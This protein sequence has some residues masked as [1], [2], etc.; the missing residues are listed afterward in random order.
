MFNENRKKAE[1]IIEKTNFIREKSMKKTVL[2]FLTLFA[3]SLFADRPVY[4][5]AILLPLTGDQQSASESINEGIEAYLNYIKQNKGFDSF[6]LKAVLFNTESKKEN[7]EK[8]IQYLAKKSDEFILYSGGLSDAEVDALIKAAEE[9]KTPYIFPI[10]SAFKEKHFQYY[11]PVL[12]SLS[13]GFKFAA[14]FFKE[15]NMDYKIIYDDS[16]R[17]NA[18]LLDESEKL[19][20][21]NSPDF[22]KQLAKAAILFVSDENVEKALKKIGDRGVKFLN[23]HQ[24]NLVHRMTDA[25][26][27]E[28]VLIL[29]W[30]KGE[31]FESVVDFKKNFMEKKKKEPDNFHM[32]GWMLAD[33]TYQGI[34]NASAKKNEKITKEDL[35]AEL[36]KM[37]ENGGYNGGC[38]YKIYYEP[39]LLSNEKSRLG[40]S[41]VYFL[42]YEK[43][44]LKI[45]SE[46][47]P[48]LN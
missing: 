22:E 48:I 1:S 18:F 41:G 32:L 3:G 47:Y 9:K 42:Q 34:V 7:S 16:T 23:Y 24:L 27:W 39:F 44:E 40:I 43:G 14:R 10:R 5:M 30:V 38:G 26:L 20:D 8:I 17:N 29:N 4:K 21:L 19:L 12:P 6:L 25:K 37:G 36:E 35:M 11:F 2:L 45:I 15:K 33:L 13:H 31:E 28:N 46:F